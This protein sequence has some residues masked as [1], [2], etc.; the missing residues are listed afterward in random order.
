[1]KKLKKRKRSLKANP[2]APTLREGRMIPV[3]AIMVNK[4]GQV[5][6]AVIR[7]KNLKKAL[8]PNPKQPKQPKRFEIRHEG[9]PLTRIYANTAAAAIKSAKFS[10]P[11]W[12]KLKLT[13]VRREI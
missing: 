8:K 1:M 4:Q 12:K 9:Y 13:A 5:V 11:G 3:D 6:K 7:D 10:F 2:K